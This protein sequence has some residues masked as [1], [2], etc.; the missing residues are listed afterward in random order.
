M[1][2]DKVPESVWT[3]SDLWRSARRLWRT[4]YEK[5]EL[6]RPVGL[7][8]TDACVVLARFD[9]LDAYSMTTGA[10]LWTWRP[11]G[12]DVVRVVSPDLEDGV[13]VVLHYDDGARDVRHVDLT[14]LD[15]ASGTVAWTRREKAERLGHLGEYH[16]E[17]ALGAGRL[18]TVVDKWGGAPK[19]RVDDVRTGRTRWSHRLTDGRSEPEAVL[20][21]APF[22]ARLEARGS[23]GRPRL[24]VGGV[25]LRLPP[26][27]AKFGEQ[28]AVTG[29]VLAVQVVPV[30]GVE[31]EHYVRLGAYSVASGEPLWEWRTRSD[32]STVVPLAHRGWLLALHGYGNRL[33]VLDPSDG[34][35]VARR[36]A[37]G[38]AFDPLVAAH[39]DVIAVACRSR[40]GTRRLRVFRWR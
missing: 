7:W 26:D 18:A 15:T 20:R 31:E 21:A 14:A 27:C 37:R 34:R 16:C 10:L 25:P 17:V 39:G 36:R 33:S 13:G 23:R 1:V 28:V 3:R 2:E 30:D 8:V 6:D 4:P 11:P 12:E 29:D 32:A 35:V 24:S 9:R 5:G 22:V 38:Y 40:S 19:L